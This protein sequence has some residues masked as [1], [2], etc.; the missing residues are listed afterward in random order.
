MAIL[1]TVDKDKAATYRAQNSKDSAH[2]G[3]SSGSTSSRTPSK[4]RIKKVPS[5]INARLANP[6]AGY[7][8][9]ELKTLG[10]DYATNH[11]SADEAEVF[12]RAAVLAANPAGFEDMDIL[13]EEEKEYLRKEITNKWKQPWELYKLVIMCS[14]AAAVQGMGRLLNSTIEG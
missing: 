9:E 7:S 10:R 3:S 14:M 1:D 12:E 13:P 2:E 11:I 8:F 5:D 6:L 4:V